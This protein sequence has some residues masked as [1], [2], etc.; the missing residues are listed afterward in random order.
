M[1]LPQDRLA[2][3]LGRALLGLALVACSSVMANSRRIG[4]PQP[5]REANCS[6][7]MVQGPNDRPAVVIGEVTCDGGETE[8]DNMVCREQIEEQLCE[9]GAEGFSPQN[10]RRGRMMVVA[11][12][13]TGASTE[14]WQ[15]RQQQQQQQQ[16]LQQQQLLL[17][18]QQQQ[19]VQ[20]Q[21]TP[22][23]A[24]CV[25]PCPA[26]SH[27]S[28]DGRRCEPDS[29]G[30]TVQASLT[31]EQIQEALD[32]IRRRVLRCRPR[33]DENDVTV[34]LEI[35]PGGSVSSVRI[36]GPL[37]NTDAGGCI[38]QAVFRATFP[39]FEGANR[40]IRHSFAPANP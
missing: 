34:E 2:V 12:R 9:L 27:C 40:S 37:A 24:Q 39:T 11:L 13:F 20:Q 30:T 8:G 21:Q 22:Q 17:Q 29:G 38:E 26:G 33:G 5:P 31:E 19:Q 7:T 10:D 15:Q 14:Q 35:E 23:P 6:L 3:F 25:P 16:Q 18:Q 36:D 28:A 4:P 32:R 1:T